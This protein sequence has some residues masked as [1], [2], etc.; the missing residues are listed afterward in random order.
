MDFPQE[1]RPPLTAPPYE[2]IF[3]PRAEK[4]LNAL[5]GHLHGAV[6]PSRIHCNVKIYNYFFRGFGV[7]S[8]RPGVLL[9]ALSR[10]RL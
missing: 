1:K 7:P 6:H 5:P 10:C 3:K 8:G 4:D 2:I 9:G